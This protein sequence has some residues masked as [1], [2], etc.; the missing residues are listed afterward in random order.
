MLHRCLYTALLLLTSVMAFADDAVWPGPIEDGYLLPNGWRITPAGTAIPTED[1]ILNLLPSADGRVVVATH[2]GYNAH[3]LVVMDATSGEPVQRIALPTAWL[4][5]AWSPD[6]SRLFVSG[7]NSRKG[8]APIYVFSYADGKLSDAPV[9]EFRD[10][11]EAK[12]TYWAGVVHHPRKD[13]IYAASRTTGV[14]AVF[15]SRSGAVLSHIDVDINPYDLVMSPDGA[16]LY[17]SNWGSD[18]VSVIDTAKGEVVRTLGV[19]NNPNDLALA[20]DGRLFVC[21]SNDNSVHVIDT[22][23]LRTVEILKTSMYPSAPEGSTPNALA[24][25]PEEETLYV[26]NA[27]NYNVCVMDVEEQ[28]EGTVLGFIPSGW[29]PSAVAVTTDGKRLFT[30]NAKGAGSYSNIRGP[31][32]PLLDAPEGKG[33]V[34]TLMKGTVSLVDIPRHKRILRKLT[35]QAYANCPYNDDL[36]NQAL[37]PAKGESVVP[38]AVG[39]GSPI[40]HVIY[41]I[42]ENR[43]YDQVL[44]DL[45]QGNGDPRLTI[46]GRNITPNTHAIVEQF[47]LFDNLYC[48]AEVSADG[49]QWTN[50]AYATDFSEKNWPAS[51]GGKSDSPYSQA[52]IPNSGYLWDQ[53]A[54]KGLTYRNY[55]EF[56]MRQSEKEPMSAIHGIGNLQG[57]IAPNYLSWDARDF[58]N[59]AEFIREFDQYEANF[60]SKDPEQRLPNLIVLALPEDHTRGTRPG[61]PTPRAAVASND[62]ALGLIVERVTKS[63]YWPETA[64]FTIQDDAQDGPDHVDARRTVGMLIS[65]Y[66]KRGTVDSTFYTTCSMLRTIELLL[67][68]PPMSQYDAAATPMYAALGTKADLSGYTHLTSNIDLE[69]RN[70]ATAWGAD[71]SM[72]MDFSDYD[73]TPMFA[74]N[75]IVW[76]SIRGADSEMP[77]PVH[78][79][80]VASLRE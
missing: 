15:D 28:G 54:K 3:G 8:V 74:L 51:Y 73:R 70:I 48:D 59:A 33:T 37:P 58:E 63:K 10:T 50:A 24:L 42:K 2:G 79:F 36:L 35:K 11:L 31:H 69:E 52:A 39:Q 41:I 32:S 14:I 23:S 61:E 76:K 56:A 38:S 75:E 45:P 6:G 27:D 29:Y 12:D 43:T 46:F 78:S 34:K 57:H 13:L 19:G 49:H 9:A 22:K 66:V 25:D 16:T 26:A 44:G 17:V 62:F 47:V 72:Q 7:G 55:G 71:E 4:G 53:C 67:G 68:L 18:S 60:D 64:I 80:S 30:G 21:C 1:L 65:P 20:K 5:L 40:K 77:V